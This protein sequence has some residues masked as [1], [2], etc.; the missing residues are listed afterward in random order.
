MHMSRTAVTRILRIVFIVWLIVTAG[1]LWQ[2]VRKS[3]RSVPDVRPNLL[4]SATKRSSIYSNV[5]GS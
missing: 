1:L 3:P 4:Q 2:T 5:V